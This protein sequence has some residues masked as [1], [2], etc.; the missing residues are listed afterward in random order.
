MKPARQGNLY[1]TQTKQHQVDAT[2][3]ILLFILPVIMSHLMEASN[4]IQQEQ[5]TLE[6]EIFMALKQ[7]VTNASLSDVDYLRDLINFQDLPL[8]I[9]TN[10]DIDNVWYQLDKYT[11]NNVENG[12]LFSL[13]VI[14]VTFLFY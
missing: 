9:E 2:M 12:L 10:V 5:V 4:C 14:Y 6:K 7:N 11:N 3:L 8:F 13:L 1:K